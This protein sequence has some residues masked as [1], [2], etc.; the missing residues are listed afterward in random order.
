M[1]CWRHRDRV[2]VGVCL[3]CGRGLC[4]EDCAHEG[5]A[6]GDGAHEE[7][8]GLHCDAACAARLRGATAVGDPPTPW[9]W[10]LALV[11]LGALALYY[12]WHQSEWTLSVPNLLGMLFLW[13]GVVLLLQRFAR[14]R[15]P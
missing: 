8:R 7:G 6:H 5:G 14:R 10:S 3:A 11:A 4:A 9:G 15:G 12:G 2:A 1:N 13:Y